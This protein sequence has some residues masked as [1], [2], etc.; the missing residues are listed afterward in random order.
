MEAW[1]ESA[2][3]PSQKGGDNLDWTGGVCRGSFSTLIENVGS[4]QF[5]AYWQCTSPVNTTIRAYV[6]ECLRFDDGS[7]YCDPNSEGVGQLANA[8]QHFN[9]SD[10]Y[11]GCRTG[12]REYYRPVARQMTVKGATVTN[13]YGA[14]VLSD[15]QK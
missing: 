4:I 13:K 15:C 10:A 6:Q 5:G 3:K 11:Y 12:T 1:E 2:P 14:P 9:R 7:F 8:T